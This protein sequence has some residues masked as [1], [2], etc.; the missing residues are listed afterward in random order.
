LNQ[1]VK[2]D[3]NQSI[4]FIQRGYLKLHLKDTAGACFDFE[5]VVGWGFD[6]FTPWIRENC[7]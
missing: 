2:I 6:E 7:N 4:T 5:K 1:S 3:D